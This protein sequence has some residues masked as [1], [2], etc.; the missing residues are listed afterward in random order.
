M[1][2]LWHSLDSVGGLQFY[3]LCI[4]R[5]AGITRVMLLKWQADA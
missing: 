1:L 5:A 4:L 3:D 2:P